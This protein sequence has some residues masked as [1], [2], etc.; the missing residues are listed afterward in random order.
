MKKFLRILSML[1]VLAM[2][3]AT[4]AAC[5]DKGNTSDT[6][7]TDTQANTEDTGSDDPITTPTD[8]KDVIKITNK[9]Q[10]LILVDQLNQDPNASKGKTYKLISDIDL[11]A[12]W[13]ASPSEKL[14][15]FVAPDA[16]T[17]FAG[18]TEFYGVFDG[19]GKTISGVYMAD[20]AEAGANVAIFKKLNGGTIKNLTVNTAFIYDD[21]AKG[22]VVSGLVGTVNGDNAVIENVTVNANVYAASDSAA[23]VAGV[24]GKVEAENLTVKD[25]TFGGRV[26]NVGS[27][28]K[29]ESPSTAAILGQMIADGGDKTIAMSGCKANG[30][31]LSNDGATKDA[32]CGKGA[33]KLTK[34]DCTETAPEGGGV[35]NQIVEIYTAEEFKTLATLESDFAGKTV[36]LMRDILLN[37]DWTASET[38]PTDVWAGIAEFKGELDGNGKIISGLYG[39]SFIGTL[40]G[41]TVKNFLLLNSAFVSSDDASVGFIGTVNGGKVVDVY[42]EAKVYYTGTAD[43]TVGGIA[44]KTEGAST[45]EN[46]VFAGVVSANG[47]TADLIANGTATYKNVLAIGTGATTAATGTCVLAEKKDAAFLEGNTEYADWSYSAYLEATAPKTITELLRF[48]KLTPDTSWYNDT[49]TTFEI[50]TPEQLLGLSVLGQTN[51][52]EGKT[53]KL[54]ANIN[55]NPTWDAT[56]AIST[57]GNVTLAAAAYNAWTPIPLFKGTLDGQGFRISGI[58]SAVTFEGAPSDGQKYVGGFITELV[59]GAVKNLIV[60]NSMAVFTPAPNTSGTSRLRIGGFISRVVDSDISV[61]YAD[62]DA[63]L[64]FDKHFSMGGFICSIETADSN[65]N[66]AGTIENI[67][68]AGSCGRIVDGKWNIT[69][70]EGSNRMYLGNVIGYAVN[71]NVTATINNVA[72]IGWCNGKYLRDTVKATITYTTDILKR[73]NNNNT[74]LSLI[75]YALFSNEVADNWASDGYNGLGFNS[76]NVNSSQKST[77]ESIGYVT[78]EF[79][80]GDGNAAVNGI[81]PGAVVTMLNAANNQ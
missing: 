2:L 11:Y 73:D 37:T 6:E 15:K 5:G 1:M 51:N 80:A 70:S 13:D 76:W 34:T 18:I 19:N 33:S 39:E 3:V 53:I 45:F 78:Y 62:M 61:I 26:G 64:C 17:E 77:Y 25:V 75:G 57:A 58:Y 67:V 12:G 31:I 10:F 66:Y 22:A 4:F 48:L 44:G 49:D 72:F 29:I 9:D 14:G 41:G 50:S 60:D 52:F 43:A 55:L 79:I 71:K 24:V 16:I 65:N 27:D 63:W 21:G 56:T 20:T 46:V 28:L 38:A 74:N 59:D 69:G 7:A 40:N 81:L 30:A 23:T 32:F 42:S 35:V 36:K 54:T 8:D 47:K 68:Y